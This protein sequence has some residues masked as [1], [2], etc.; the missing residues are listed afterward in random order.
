M[1]YLEWSA[2]TTETTTKASSE[3]SGGSTAWTASPAAWSARTIGTTRA[4]TPASS[5]ASVIASAEEVQTVT[6]VQH[7]IAGNGVDFLVS[8]TVGVDGTC[9]VGLFAQDVVPLQHHSKHLAL[10]EAVRQLSIPQQFVGIQRLV[11]VA[12]SAKTVEI[13]REAGTPRKGDARVATVVVI[14][15]GKVVRCLQ[16]ILCMGIGSAAVQ[17]HVEP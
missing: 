15:R 10:E 17:R 4:F 5:T 14:P 12:A 8:P 7:G 11:V 13:G 16:T 2:A 3:A 6:D 1:F 9:K